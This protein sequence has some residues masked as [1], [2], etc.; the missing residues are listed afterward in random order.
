MSPAAMSDAADYPKG[1]TVE[2]MWDGLFWFVLWTALNY[3]LFFSAPLWMPLLPRSSKDNENTVKWNVAQVGSFI[4]AALI[5]VISV[6]C[7][8]V[9]MVAPADAQFPPVEG[10][11]PRCSVPI[12]QPEMLP[13]DD[14]YQ[15][16]AMAGLAFTMH[17]LSDLVTGIL[18]Q[19]T[20][21]Q[22]IAHHC[23]F[24][25]VGLIIRGHCMLPYSSA[26]L[27]AMEVS[28]PFLN[29]FNVFRNRGERYAKLAKVSSIIFIVTFVIFRLL[30][31]PYSV[32]V[33]WANHATIVPPGTPDWQVRFL[34]VALTAGA[35]IQFY[36]FSQI[37][38]AF[39]PKGPSNPAAPVPGKASENTQDG[40]KQTTSLTGGTLPVRRRS[41]FCV[42]E[43][44]Q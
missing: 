34:L 29:V 22:M 9:F 20:G 12:N 26:A 43:K 32:Y 1:F 14:T 28:T 2:L 42:S 27:M 41:A 4:H 5:A 44:V 38:K 31:N 30:V 24:I 19:S 33:L 3:A 18:H 23:A 17:I 11:Q 8:S 25:T 36:F 15:Y 10:E 7:L 35:A 13:W 40:E 21:A 16:T 6:Y 39:S 37:V